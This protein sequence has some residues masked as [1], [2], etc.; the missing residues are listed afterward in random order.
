MSKQVLT[1]KQEATLKR[2]EELKALSQM[3]KP[4]VK[5]GAFDTVNEAIIDIYKEETGAKE[6][7]T[8]WGWVNNGYSVKKGEKSFAVWAKPINLN[9]MVEGENMT[10]EKEKKYFPMCNL[11]GDHQVQSSEKKTVNN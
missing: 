11:F 1:K 3:V 4:M 9:D 8:F 2:R 7:K 5:Q 6:F 10:P